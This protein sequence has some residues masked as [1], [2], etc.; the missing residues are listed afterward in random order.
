MRRLNSLLL[1]FCTA[2]LL[3]LS[4]CGLGSGLDLPSGRGD[5]SP[6]DAGGDPVTGDPN[7][8]LDDDFGGDGDGQIDTPPGT[9]G[10]NQ[11]ADE[12]A[13]DP[14]AMGG[15]GGESG[16]DPDATGGDGSGGSHP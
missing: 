1:V 9:D 6:D 10:E 12:E 3:L 16:D 5:S 8:D 4:G 15:A 7:V 13:D 14:D 2:F 11:G